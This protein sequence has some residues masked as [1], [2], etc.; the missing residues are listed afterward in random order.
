MQ[1]Q[2]SIYSLL[3]FDIPEN[4][5]LKGEVDFSFINEQLANTY[6]K[7]YGRPSRERGSI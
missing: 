6:S 4:H 3:N 2:L 5:K 7:Y 1:L